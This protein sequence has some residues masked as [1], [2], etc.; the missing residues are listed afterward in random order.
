LAE[1][2]TRA[3]DQAEESEAK[4]KICIAEKDALLRTSNEAKQELLAKLK[5][6]QEIINEKDQ[7]LKVLKLN[8][9]VF[10]R[11][12]KVLRLKFSALFCQLSLNMLGRQQQLILLVEKDQQVLQMGK[13][14]TITKRNVCIHFEFPAFFKRPT[15]RREFQ[16]I[17]IRSAEIGR[18]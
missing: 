1:L 9:L 15:K 17:I 10:S 6:L 18:R 2:A 12:Q 13:T 3:T 16:I 14:I 11:G 8:Q 7:Q 5:T 4:V